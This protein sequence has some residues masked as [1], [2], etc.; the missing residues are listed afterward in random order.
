MLSSRRIGYLRELLLINFK[1]LK[2][3][4]CYIKIFQLLLDLLDII[5]SY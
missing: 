1:I 2:N 3:V 5:L 4:G